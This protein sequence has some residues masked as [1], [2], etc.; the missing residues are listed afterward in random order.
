MSATPQD[1]VCVLTF[2]RT[3]RFVSESH[4]E[5]LELRGLIECIEGFWVL[6]E[7]GWQVA[8]EYQSMRLEKDT[9]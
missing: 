2:Q 4:R 8:N 7:R 6:S 1:V 5:H 3:C 9:G